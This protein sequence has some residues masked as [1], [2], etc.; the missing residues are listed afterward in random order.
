M[1]AT[2]RATGGNRKTVITAIGAN[3][4]I[5]CTKFAAAL[6]TGSSSLMSE[7]IHSTVDTANEA[8][9]LLGLRQSARP[10][11]RSHP[12][13]YG[14]ELYFWSFVVAMLIFSLGAGFSIY[15]GL[16]GLSG[17][18]AI[19]DPLV[20]FAVLVAAFVFEGYSWMVA[21]REFNHT[22]GDEGFFRHFR[23]HKDPAIF[24]VLIE[25][26]V[27]CIGVAIAVA[28]LA[29]SIVFANP[30][31][32]AAGAIAI[33]LLLALAAAMLAFETKGL[34]IGEA[35]SVAFSAKVRE[36]VDGHP[37][38]KHLNELRTMHFGPHEVLVA[39]SV[40]FRDGLSSDQVEAAVS[41]LERQITEALPDAR[42]V[43]IE[44]QGCAS[45]EAALQ[46]QSGQGRDP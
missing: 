4:L 9:L 25:D 26:S 10:A 20:G 33:G 36:L 23:N 45:H 44:A 24:V 42:R 19:E 31:Y 28:A 39:L 40:D 17:E 41:A 22:R 1:A 46:G 6:F 34:L 38:A 37:D 14:S 18:E 30:V 7:G 8:L 5:A 27:A 35:A 21:F 13:G 32:D 2:H 43:F 12:F 11:D 3:A 16:K 29:L 15:E